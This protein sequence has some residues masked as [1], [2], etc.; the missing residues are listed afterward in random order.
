MSA[1][2]SATGRIQELAESRHV[3]ARSAASTVVLPV[4]DE[5][6]RALDLLRREQFAAALAVVESIPDSPD[7]EPD[8]LLLRAVLLIQC[9]R[10]DRAAETCGRLLEGHGADAGAHYLLGLCRESTGDATAATE[11]NRVAAHLDP[12]FALPRLRLGILARRSGDVDTA[13]RELGHALGLLSREDPHRLLLFAGGFA[14]S[15]LTELCRSELAA[16]GA[17]P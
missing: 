6:A 13:R 16:C 8:T 15:A 7:S 10:T 5:R 11:H 12:T 4:R 2:G 3:V 9:G 17:A 1:I 14:R